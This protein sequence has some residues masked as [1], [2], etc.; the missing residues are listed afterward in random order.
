VQMAGLI[1]KIFSNQD[2]RLG[3]PDAAAGSAEASEWIQR[4]DAAASK[5]YDI[6]R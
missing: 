6:S 2:H 4:L 3:L 1:P 5:I